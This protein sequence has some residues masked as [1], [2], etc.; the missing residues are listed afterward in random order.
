VPEGGR[1][2]TVFTREMLADDLPAVVAIEVASFKTPWTPDMLRDELVQG[3]SWRVA[4]VD[5]ASGVVGF[6]IGRRYPDVWH[7][8]DLAVAPERRRRGIG[9]LLL[10][11]FLEAADAAGMAVVLEVRQGNTEATAL[12]ESRGFALVGVRR[13]YYTD[14]GED[15]LVM[16]REPGGEGGT[17]G[18]EGRRG[19]EAQR[20]GG[21]EGLSGPLLAIESSC[22]DS[23]AAVLTPAGEVLASV[24]HSQDAI[25]ERYG[26]VV[27]EV[28]SRAHVERM[29][30]VVREALRQAGCRVNDLGG[31]AATVGPGLIGALLV[32]VQ[33]AKAIAWSH[34][35]P[36]F[37]VNHIHGHLAAAWLADPE[38]P[39][40]M[41]TLVASGGHT[42]LIRVR[43]RTTFRLLGQTL[44]DAA[45]EAFDKGARLLRLGYPGG[46]E[47]DELAE[48]GNAKA[49][50]FPIGLKRSARPDFSFSGVKTALYY[51]LR[52]M[53]PQER[54]DK[55][56]DIAASYREAIVEALV[57]KA[58]RTAQRE[59]V[60][61][62]AVAGG[63]ASNSLLRR[64]LV[65]A[66]S[67]VGLH[68]VIP[69][70]AY[71]TDN[72]AMIGAAALGAPRF[73]YPD[74]LAIDA[75]A[76]LALGQWF[77]AA[78]TFDKS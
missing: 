7:V 75:S 52:D 78:S 42:V 34:R 57:S 2:T 22:D 8:M 29:T 30:A 11:G 18:G 47:L 74:Y 62:L 58:V 21:P 23:A 68:V 77:P 64:R 13:G 46:R 12:Y 31:V 61:T 40:P 41:V 27:P 63:V 37:P 33:T 70:L 26:G 67:A 15:A 17:P 73:D 49:F 9:G 14:S 76:S 72:A 39:F 19:D 44:D 65:E 3:L 10:A 25:H 45:G 20:G 38:A 16:A 54:S 60:R 50:S 35:L 56:A 43:D 48:K 51:V 59:R 4:A 36:F 55:A 53:S 5:P 28:A 32:G 69:P 1:V 24:T 71:C 66:G 6:M